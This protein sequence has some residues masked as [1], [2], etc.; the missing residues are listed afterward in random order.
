MQNSEDTADE[1]KVKKDLLTV[2][3]ATSVS[4]PKTLYFLIFYLLGL[5][6]EG[7]PT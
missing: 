4:I 3:E 6:T 2:P 1:V 7:M 5:V